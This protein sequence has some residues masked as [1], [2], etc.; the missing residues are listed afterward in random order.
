MAMSTISD[1]GQ[2]TLPVRMRRQLKLKPRDT[3]TIDAIG[4]AIIIKRA[5]DF[6]ELKGFLGEALPADIEKKRMQ[7][8]VSIH[9]SDKPDL[10]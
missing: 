10:K 5:V 6:F 9:V 1:K 2:I 8:A 4:D 3:V 7:S